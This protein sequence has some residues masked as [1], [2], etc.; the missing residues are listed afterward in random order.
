MSDKFKNKYRISS[1]RL[2]NWD[3]SSNAAY[4]I[5]VCTQN[6]IHFFGKIENQRMNLSPLG[7]CVEHEWLKTIEIRRDM[8]LNM[9]EYVVMPN[10]FH[11]IIGIGK[12]AYNTNAMHGCRDAMHGRDA[13]HCVSTMQSSPNMFGPQYKNLASIIRGFKSAVTTY[14]R[15]QGDTDFAWQPRYHDHII[16]NE[17]SFKTIAQYILNNPKQWKEDQFNENQNLV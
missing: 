16:R 3:Y 10:H 4:F 12:N 14:A 15:K 11:G 8:N 17:Q 9:G 13:M 1:T 5:T 2:Q 7:Q 6:R